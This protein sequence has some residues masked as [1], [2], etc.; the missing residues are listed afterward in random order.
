M[1][2][3]DFRPDQFGVAAQD[4]CGDRVEGA[5]PAQALRRR[6]DQMG[7]PLAHLARGLVGE[8]D[9]Q[10][11]PRLRAAGG[12]DVGEA[13][14]QHPRLAGARARQ[15]QHGALDRLHRRALFGV[16]PREVVR[17]ARGR[18]HP[19]HLRDA[20]FAGAEGSVAGEIVV[21]A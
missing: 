9:H 11:F 17:R 1:V 5:E 18:I 12:E 19:R 21:H 7:D 14:G 8:G 6:A 16:Q 3:L 15:H 20:E 2:K 10:Q 13:R 4:L